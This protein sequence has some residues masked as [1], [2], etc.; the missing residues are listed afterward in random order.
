MGGVDPDGG[1][2]TNVS[3]HSV[4]EEEMP[5]FM[6]YGKDSNYSKIWTIGARVLAHKKTYMS[7]L[8][9]T[10]W[11]GKLTGYSHDSVTYRVNNLKTH[12]VVESQNATSIEPRL[13]ESRRRLN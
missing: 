4:L 11:E 6:L 9:P 8:E 10:A 1:V 12:R 7:K 13:K 2:S 5:Y 3:P